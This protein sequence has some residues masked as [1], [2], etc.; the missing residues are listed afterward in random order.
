MRRLD[1]SYGWQTFEAWQ[2]SQPADLRDTMTSHAEAASNVWEVTS[3]PM[4][5]ECVAFLGSMNKR[6]SLLYRGQPQDWPLIPSLFRDC[7]TAFDSEAK[8]AIAERREQYWVE[9]QRIGRR[10]YEVLK[11]KELGL[12]RRRGFRDT[13]EIQ[14]AVAQHY[15]LWPTPLIDVTSSLRVAATFAMDFSCGTPDHPR[16]GYLYVLGMPNVTGSITV[17]FDQHLLLAR[18][19]S[20]CPP[21]AKR[22]HCQE[23]FLVGHFPLYSVTEVSTSKVDLG[24]RL[25]AKFRLIDSGEFWSP[26]FPILSQAALMPRVDALMKHF[27]AVFGSESGEG[28]SHSIAVGLK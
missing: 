13:R 2:L 17:D 1:K 25:I 18:L 7:W 3:F 6:L 16:T 21:A 19:Q 27:V 11:Q 14:W 4:L 10:V 5:I 15:G 26:D 20:C 9:L 24:Q 23:G 28:S 8:L 12:P 22:P